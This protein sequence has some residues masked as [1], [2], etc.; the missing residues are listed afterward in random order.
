MPP[1]IALFGL[2]LLLSGFFSGS[3]TA[4]L[5]ASRLRLRRLAADGDRAAA[6]AL[7]LVKDPRRLLAGILVGNNVV[8]TLAASTATVFCV[9]VLALGEARGVAIATA[10]STLLLVLFAEFLP[11]SVSASHPEVIARRVALPVQGAIRLLAPAVW[12]LQALT[13]PL[14][15]ILK[16]AKRDGIAVADL[17]LAVAE[18]ARTGMLDETMARVLRGGLSLAWK[19]V[20]DA[21]VPRVDVRGVDATSGYDAC[22]DVF[23]RDN[24]SRLLVMSGTP[25]NDLGYLSV[26]DMPQIPAERR[27]AWKA[28]DAV[29][30]AL[31][32]PA[33]LSLAKL[34]ARMRRSGV[35]FAVVKD[36]HGG[37]DGIATLEDVLEE[38]VGEIRDEHDAEEHPPVR[39][40]A[41]GSWVVRGDVAVLEVND[42]LGMSLEA[43]E[44]HTIGGLIA[45]LLGRLP[46]EGEAV[47]GGGVRLVAARVS[48][49]R[50]LEVLV[51][52]RA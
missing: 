47:E 44:A 4:L 33:T 40:T 49:R 39:E 32:V 45:E 8:N 52:R 22:L 27:A 15:S 7:E 6:R 21:L 2:C 50:V 30:Q 13:R 16:G 17:R 24:Y 10:A 20:A 48:G 3:E 36:E 18:S 35:H 5:S 26:K 29:R 41:P 23:R 12:T 42:R 19:T 31:R 9:H 43:E 28:G 11:K 46:R 14:K 1:E 34:L 25:D 51:E 38:L 37:T